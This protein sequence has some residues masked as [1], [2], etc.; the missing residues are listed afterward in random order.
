MIVNGDKKG[1]KWLIDQLLMF[2][3]LFALGTAWC[4]ISSGS[5]L[6][7]SSSQPTQFLHQLSKGF[8]VVKT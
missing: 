3:H 8:S 5:T 6:L 7:I 1:D 4:L 2:S